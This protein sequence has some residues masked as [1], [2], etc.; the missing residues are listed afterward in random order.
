M[1]GIK[2]IGTTSFKTVYDIHLF[3]TVIKAITCLN[4]NSSKSN[5]YKRRY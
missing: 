2:Q 1:V 3:K 4:Q 5:I